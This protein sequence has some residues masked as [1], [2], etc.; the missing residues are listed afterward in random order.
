MY[1]SNW[2]IFYIACLINGYSEVLDVPSLDGFVQYIQP[3]Q[4]TYTSY[5]PPWTF[6]PGIIS[7]TIPND[8][9]FSIFNFLNTYN[10]E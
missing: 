5:S 7:D 2:N 3:N 6:F 4:Q 9:L 1:V 10:I 8:Y